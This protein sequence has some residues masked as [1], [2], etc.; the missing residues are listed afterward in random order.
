MDGVLRRGEGG[1]EAMVERDRRLLEVEEKGKIF[2]G[3]L[4]EFRQ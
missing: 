4:T 3:T 1:R 2:G